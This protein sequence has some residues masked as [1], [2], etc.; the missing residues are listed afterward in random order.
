MWR[1]IR[2]NIAP[3]LQKLV[4]LKKWVKFYLTTPTLNQGSLATFDYHTIMW[5]RGILDVK[6][7]LVDVLSKPCEN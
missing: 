7:S 2:P 4:I 5:N 6:D 3:K 1:Q